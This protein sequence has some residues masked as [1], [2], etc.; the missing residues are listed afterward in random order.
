METTK[1]KI[2]IFSVS[3]VLAIIVIVLF[4]IIWRHGRIEITLPDDARKVVIIHQES[5]EEILSEE[6]ERDIFRATL[7]SG[8]YE[9]RVSNEDGMKVSSYFITIPNFLQKIEREAILHNQV[10][11]QKIGR[12]SLPC[13]VMDQDKLYSYTCSGADLLVE[14]KTLTT[15]NHSED[16][17]LPLSGIISAQ[18]YKDGI[19]VLHSEVYLDEQSVVPLLS[20]VRDGKIIETRSD[21]PAELI[22]DP[23]ESRDYTLSL[24]FNQSDRFV[25][26]R[27][28]E[29]TAFIFDDFDAQPVNLNIDISPPVP[30]DQLISSIGLYDNTLT[31][32]YSTARISAHFDPTSQEGDAIPSENVIYAQRYTLPDTSSAARLEQEYTLGDIQAEIIKPCG[33]AFICTVSETN[34]TVYRFEESLK[35]IAILQGSSQDIIPKTDD[36]FLYIQGDGVFEFNASAL[37][38]HQVYRSNNF[39][40][41]TLTPSGGGVIMNAFLKTDASYDRRQDLYSFFLGNEPADT[42]F[43]L[44]SIMP[45]TPGSVDGAV[46]TSDYFRDIIEIRVALESW[47]SAARVSGG[48]SDYTYDEVEFTEKRDRILR[49]L[50]E[51]G[52]NPDEYTIRI[53]P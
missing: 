43:F 48:A 18:S 27:D 51:D 26:S 39:R 33:K 3:A 32:A 20:F 35:K 23:D 5:G 38:A 30:V 24:D 44:D 47:E 52:I 13:P 46:R 21:L 31:L 41:S 36:T 12:N 14:A 25:I 4:S 19:L 29:R 7:A 8:D 53:L 49:Q 9:A 2:I 16:N 11:R 34:T 37:E 6:V 50:E 1:R 22:V 15:Q 10:T 17:E 45:Y 28:K 42:N 40:I